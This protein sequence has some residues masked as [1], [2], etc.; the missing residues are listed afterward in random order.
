MAWGWNGYGQ[1]TVPSP[2]TDFTAIAAGFEHSL[3]LK[4]DGSI[5]AWGSNGYGQCTVPSPNTDFTAIAAG[6]EHSLGLKQDGSIVAWGWNVSGQCTVPSPNTDFTAIATLGYHSLALKTDGSIVG[7]G[8]NDDGQASPPYGNN[9]IAIAASL[10]HS[11]GLVVTYTIAAAAGDNGSIDPAGEVVVAYQK[12]FTATGSTGYGVD[13]WYVDG[14]VAQTGGNT[15]TLTNITTD[16]TVYV[17]FRALPLYTITAAAGDNGSIEP[18]G[19]VV[20][21][22]GDNKLFTA[23][24]NP[25]YLVGT[26]YVDGNSVHQ[27]GTTYTLHNVQGSHTVHVTFN[28]AVLSIISQ[29]YSVSG[30]AYCNYG[31]L[32]SYSL[33]ANYP[34]SGY[35]ESSGEGH[36]VSAES[37]SVS[38]FSSNYLSCEVYESTNY[39]DLPYASGDASASLNIQ[40]STPVKSQ[41]RVIPEG[42]EMSFTWG[43]ATLTDITAGRTYDLFTG[44]NDCHAGWSPIWQIDNLLIP[45]YPS[46]TYQISMSTGQCEGGTSQVKFGFEILSFDSDRSPKVYYVDVN[47]PN[48]PGTGTWFDPYRKIQD[49]IYSPHVID[50]DT[51]VVMPGTYYENLFFGG[52]RI[53]LIGASLYVP[54]IMGASIIDGSQPTNPHLASVIEF[55]GIED[56]NSVLKGFTLTGGAG[57][58]ASDVGD[59]AGSAVYGNGSSA[60]IENCLIVNNTFCGNGIIYNFNGLLKNCTIVNNTVHDLALYRCGVEIRNCIVWGNSDLDL[61]YFNSIVPTYSCIQGFGAPDSY[62]NFEADPCF[63]DSNNGDYHLL[64]DSPCIDAGDPNYVAEAGETDFEGNPRIIGGRIDIGAD[65]YWDGQRSDLNHDGKVN[66]KDYSIFAYYWLEYVC[67]EPDWCEGCDYDHSGVVDLEDLQRFAE[68]WMCDVEDISLVGYWKFDEG[69]GQFALDLSGHGNKGTL[70]NG[71]SWGDGILCF[72]GVDDWVE[73]NDSN[74][75]DITNQ[76]TLSAWVYF[77]NN[78]TKWTKIVIKPYQSYSDPWEL[79]CIDFGHNKPGSSVYNI[80]RFMITDGLTTGNY[81]G[82]YDVNYVLPEGSWHQVVGTYDGS[83]VR[84]YVD[85]QPVASSSATLQIGTNN[86]PLSIG[87]RLGTNDSFN[88][89]V[90]NVRIYNRALTQDEVLD[91]YNE[92]LLDHS[93]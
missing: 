78:P 77:D 23:T 20:A 8:D 38:D 60:I 2:N 26:W 31:H 18:A 4:Q 28:K 39:W 11:L 17:T 12:L 90:D 79:Y 81:G 10:Y 67:S 25:G 35:A 63:V 1:C 46:H 69:T 36:T 49:A 29:T 51:V 42:V 56:N 34:V 73:V 6:G 48:D 68:D 66:S 30:E 83:I 19:E 55:L 80:P 89:C 86:M 41:V 3:G 71:T 15:Y 85:G 44:E 24:A 16:N 50:G 84:L 33:S 7:W 91:L 64:P 40:F 9:F 45:I 87:G 65:E 32:D 47:S 14:N 93:Q 58:Y 21:Y 62:G 5:V 88:G 59:Y 37:R 74:T 82:A 52:K 92:E 13:T 76:I 27:G 72:D 75:L 57:R 54:N 22:Q 43:T 53:T 70:K 61:L